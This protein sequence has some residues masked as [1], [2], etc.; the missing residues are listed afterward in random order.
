MGG[1][2]RDPR[3]RLRA[4]SG[5]PRVEAIGTEGVRTPGACPMQQHLSGILHQFPKRKEIPLTLESEVGPLPIVQSP[6]GLA[7]DSQPSGSRKKTDRGRPFTTGGANR[8][9]PR[10]AC[11]LRGLRGFRVPDIDLFASTLNFKLPRF[12]ARVPSPGEWTVDVLALDWTDL[13][14][15]AFSLSS[16]EGA[17]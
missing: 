5:V 17:G 13:H 12:V 9:V 1:V 15:Y 10:Y 7:E 6:S 16:G 4:A 11:R 2:N 8:V 14:G 3:Q